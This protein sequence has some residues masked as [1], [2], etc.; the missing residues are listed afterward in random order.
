M[1][2][3]DEL[4]HEPREVDPERHRDDVGSLVRRPLDGLGDGRGRPAARAHNLADERARDA[5]RDA[6]PLA[7]DVP[8]EDRTGAVRAVTVLVVVGLGREDAAARFTPWNAGWFGSIPVS[9]TA[10]VIPAP[11]KGEVVAP[12]AARPRREPRRA[13]N[14][15]GLARLDQ[16]HRHRSSDRPGIRVAPKICVLSLLRSAWSDLE[17]LC[18]VAAASARAEATRRGSPTVRRARSCRRRTTYDSRD[19]KTLRRVDARGHPMRRRSEE[20]TL[21]LPF[22]EPGA[23]TAEMARL[24]AAT[25]RGRVQ[26]CQQMVPTECLLD[27]TADECAPAYP[28][29]LSGL[30]ARTFTGIALCRGI[31]EIGSKSRSTAHQPAGRAAGSCA[32]PPSQL[33]RAAARVRHRD[34][35]GAGRRLDAAATA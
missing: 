5:A 26:W 7:A 35:A 18:V 29:E 12:T 20:G 8:A 23:V 30:S 16:L 10:T 33:G 32:D 9:G 19:M 13:G 15:L 25:Q 17:I 14:G 22:P 27:S 21:Q 2:D 3:L 34:R 4:L 24:E 11:S 1:L 31:P 28:L 6:D